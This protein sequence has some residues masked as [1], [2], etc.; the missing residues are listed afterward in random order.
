MGSKKPI[1]DKSALDDLHDINTYWKD[2]QPNFIDVNDISTI[3]TTT[4]FCTFQLEGTH[5]WPDCPH[6][7]VAYLRDP[8]RHMFHFKA[9]KKV[10]HADRDV[11][12]I[13][14]K[15]EI[16]NY[17]TFKYLHHNTNICMF[18]AQSCEMLAYEIMK[19][20]ELCACEVSE[21]GENGAFVQI[22]KPYH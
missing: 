5:N 17:M 7:E 11:E 19:E 6:D 3:S 1:P 14:L 4:V 16:V 9:Y 22:E 18:G 15:H 2:G 21:D 8:H 10:S 12:F 20:F 13:M